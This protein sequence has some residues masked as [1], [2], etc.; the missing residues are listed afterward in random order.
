MYKNDSLYYSNTEYS[1]EMKN[2]NWKNIN[3]LFE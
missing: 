2:D 3:S 1:E